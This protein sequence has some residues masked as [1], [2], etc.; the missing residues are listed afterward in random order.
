MGTQEIPDHIFD[1]LL[2]GLVFYEAELTLI[3]FEPG[4]I[5]LISDS[6]GT[7]L[8]WLWRENSAK[9]TMLVADFVAQLRYYHPTA[10]RALTLDVVLRGLPPA[11]RGV[12][13]EEIA[14]MLEQ[15]RCDVPKYVGPRA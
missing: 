2:V 12:P 11:L 6:F 14:A 1:Q 15:F 5:A 13:S 8:T 7:M 10:N 4:G 9:A 3:H